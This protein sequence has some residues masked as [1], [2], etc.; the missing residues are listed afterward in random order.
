MLVKNSDLKGLT[1]LHIFR[2]LNMKSCFWKPAC[3]CAL[4]APEHWD[5]FYSRLAF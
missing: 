4:L 3:L 2:P 5:K 1:N